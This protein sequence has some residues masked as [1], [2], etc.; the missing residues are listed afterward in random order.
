MLLR[1]C[2]LCLI[3]VSF[4]SV[5]RL[6][7]SRPVFGVQ[8]NMQTNSKMYLLVAYIHNGRAL[9]HRKIMNMDEFV[10]IASGFWPSVYNPKK[11]NLLEMHSLPC[12]LETD[13]ITN[14]KTPGCGPLDS[15]WKLRYS[16]Y[17]F[18]NGREKGW[19]SELYKPSSKQ[20]IYLYKNYGIYDIDFSPFIDSNF[21][22]IMQDVQDPA[23]IKQYRAL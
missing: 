20:A 6:E 10:K 13:P 15:L 14:K 21:W 17:P 16:D 12:G 7:P 23:W 8:V 18:N 5:I 1:F 11:M 22:K 9:T 3:W 2:V 4:S 19:S